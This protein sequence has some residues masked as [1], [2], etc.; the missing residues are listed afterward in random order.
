MVLWIVIAAVVI[1][2]VSALAFT[3]WRL[4]AAFAIHE[5]EAGTQQAAKETLGKLRELAGRVAQQVDE[6]SHKVEE[7]SDELA[8]LDKPDE[9]DVL[10]TV[11]KLID[12][13]EHMKQQLQAAEDRLK[14]QA[15]QIESHAV[16]ARTDPLTQVANRRA[17]EDELRRG[18]DDYQ[19]RGRP[20]SVMIIDVDHFKKFNDTHGHQAGDEIL[21]SVA[22]VLR[23]STAESNLVARYGGEEFA[24]VFP[25]STFGAAR[26][27]AEKAR[28]AIAS[29]RFR[30]EGRE[31][32]VTASAGLAELMIGE[33]DVSLV[34]RADEALY[35]S[36]HAGRN[37]AHFN[38]GF[39]NHAVKLESTR[40]PTTPAKTG[41]P[42]VGDEWL[43]EPAAE[44]IAEDDPAAQVS[45]R[46]AF[47]DCMIE[48]LSIL[49]KLPKTKLSLLLVQLDGLER[50]RTEHG[51][52]AGS[53]AVRVAAQIFKANLRDLDQI[54]RLEDNTF[55]LLLPGIQG[56]D[57]LAIAQRIQSAVARYPLPKRAGVTRVSVAIGVAE[58]SNSDD[59]QAVLRRARKAL[60]NAL[61]HP[62]QRLAGLSAQDVTIK[63]PTA[64]DE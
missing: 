30:Y 31:L 14:S 5:E 8:S 59:L 51:V 7:I 57:A 10:L 18:V 48:R 37:C 49:K 41:K 62:A 13:N 64:T 17:L 21:R 33:T 27:I 56:T 3:G 39:A 15:R 26:E 1:T 20:L 52:S 16:E 19:Q 23:Q 32:R 12:V 28:L 24:I 43:Y 44:E 58:A 63:L 47:F 25:G 45:S 38:D 42:V 34:K 2:L 53:I 54:S 9:Q 61:L 55:S 36:K 4:R 29:A 46:P 50:I 11:N 22:R 35:A 40:A 60:D 6:H